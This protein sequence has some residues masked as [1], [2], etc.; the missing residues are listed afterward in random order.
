MQ[1]VFLEKNPFY[2]LEAS[3]TDTRASIV[4]KA[5]EKAF[6]LDSGSCEEAQ[7]KLLNPSKRLTAELDW[8]CDVAD[9]RLTAI[10]DSIARRAEI[11][12][13]G[14]CGLSKLN[15]MLYN[16]SVVN[17]QELAELG[18]AI[19]AIDAQ[20]EAVDRNAL[21]E[22]LNVCHAQ[23]GMR[24]VTAEEVGQTLQ[25]KREEIRKLVAEQ[26]DML[27]EEEYIALITRI[28][29][30]NIADETYQDGIIVSDLIDQYELR[31]QSAIEQTT[32]ALS[33]MIAQIQTLDDES[34][35]SQQLDLLIEKTKKWD[36]L[37]QPLQLRSMASGMSHP[38]SE[39]LGLQLRDLALHLHNEKGYTEASLHLV[40]AMKEIFAELGELSDV[41]KCD[42]ERLSEILAGNSAAEELSSKI[43]ALKTAAERI[44]TATPGVVDEFLLKVR[45]LNAQVKSSA[46]PP[47]LKKKARQN[48]CTIARNLAVKL[49][50]EREQTSLAHRLLQ[51]LMTE[52]GDIPEL[53]ARLKQDI[54]DLNLVSQ[55]KIEF[56]RQQAEREEAQAR[57]KIIVAVMLGIFLLIFLISSLSNCSSSS[58]STHKSTASTTASTTKTADEEALFSERSDSFDKVYVNIVS[59]E[60]VVG[61]RLS[62]SA[63]NTDVACKCSTSGGRTVWVYISVQDYNTYFDENAKL[64]TPFGADFEALTF[65]EARTL[66][67]IARRAESL[68]EGLSD[69]TGTMVF[70][71]VS[72]DES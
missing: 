67:G 56:A 58:S 39:K 5:E 26:T 72:M 11:G 54:R 52:F 35:I 16:F 6:F 13:E 49:H 1:A 28:A 44:Y 3:P 31:M 36:R 32:D 14:L 27:R 20:Y 25:K 21:T 51:N 57:K 48:V 43:E 60:P 17:D 46:L 29:E 41:F 55:R 4:A 7:A 63:F 34:E 22:S 70:Y 71:F 62:T 15:A 47:E 38:V 42:G 19:L 45:S 53:F 40:T 12:T 69:D 68:C 10:R 24:A 59:I 9:E 50:N 64:D 2:I 33:A 23:A 37:V 18:D 66:H 30:K 65:S 61:I 8:F